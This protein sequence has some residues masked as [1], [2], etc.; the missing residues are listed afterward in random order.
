MS[1]MPSDAAGI[2]FKFGTN[3]YRIR[4]A[5]VSAT[6]R[7]TELTFPGG[8]CLRT[9]EHLLAA[10]VGMGVDDLLIEVIG[11]EL[12]IMDGSALPFAEKIAEL[13]YVENDGISEI[14][15]LFTSRTV[16]RGRSVI[17]AVPSEHLKVTYVIDYPCAAIGTQSIDI[18]VTPESFLERLAPARTFAT[19][20]ETEFLK[21]NGFGL[22]GSLDNTLVIDD[23]K[24][25]NSGGYRLER[26]CTAHKIVDLLGD[27]ALVGHSVNAH[28]I[29]YCGGHSLH[30]ALA[31]RLRGLF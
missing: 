28:Y 8:E 29:C 10:V 1:L 13:G 24:P 21:E 16:E 7:C 12:P 27:I 4:D 30:T 17:A 20:A 2:L 18:T 5:E 14:K 22:G 15:D 23:T 19:L 11:T 3:V 31:I 25:V 26:E 9:A 6:S